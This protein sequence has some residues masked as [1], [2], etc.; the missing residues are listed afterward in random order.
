MVSKS[1]IYLV[2]VVLKLEWLFYGYESMRTFAPLYT[3]YYVFTTPA[4]LTDTHTP[5]TLPCV[6]V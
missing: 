5:V 4:F 2:V 1:L 3:L 6:V